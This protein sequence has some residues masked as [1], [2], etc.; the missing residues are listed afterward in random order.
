MRIKV[1]SK[2]SAKKDAANDFHVNKAKKDGLA[3][4]CKQCTLANNKSRKE[5]V[6]AT[7]AKWYKANK[8]TALLRGYACRIKKMFGISLEEYNE[9]LASQ[10]GVCA[11]CKRT[12]ETRLAVDHD[13]S[14]CGE[15]KA[16]PIC[17]RGLLCHDCN[18]GLGR[19]HDSPELL[20]SAINYLNS[21]RPGL[22]AAA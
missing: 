19:F 14:H 11:I 22:S 21:F 2:C 13:H 9:K 7:S 3:S 6:R 10:N 5:E 15:E 8:A 16:C 18:V 12:S 1:C 17:I 20:Q 4:W